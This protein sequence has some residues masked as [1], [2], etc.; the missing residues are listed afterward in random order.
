MSRTR[1]RPGHFDA[2]TTKVDHNGAGRRPTTAERDE[3]QAQASDGNRQPRCT[4]QAEDHKVTSAPRARLLELGA[5]PPAWR[6][7]QIHAETPYKNDVS[8]GQK[9]AVRGL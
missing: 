8:A 1:L 9:R 3:V 4:L 6:L 7:C 2:L 5:G